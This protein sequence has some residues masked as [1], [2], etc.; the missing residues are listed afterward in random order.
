MKQIQIT[1]PFTFVKEDAAV[2]EISENEVL[3]KVTHIGICGSD[4]QIYH[5]KHKFMTFPVILGHEVAAL[6]ERAGAQ[7]KGFALGDQV[8]VE[9]QMACGHCY[10]CEHGR[11]N[12]CEHLKVLGVHAD[13]FSREY[14][15]LDTKYLHRVPKTMAGELAAMVEPFAVGVGSVRRSRNIQGA[16]VAVVGAGTIG[17]FT[18]QAAKLLG[19]GKVMISD[20]NQQK[21]DYALECGID[22]A[23]NTKNMSLKDAI[24]RCFGV[25]KADVII[26]CAGSPFTF[27]AILEAARPG[28][29]VIITANFKEPVEFNVPIMQRQEITLIGHMMY[30]REDFQTAIELL[31]AGKVVTSKTITKTFGFDEY[32]GAFKYADANA[33]SVMK[34]IVKL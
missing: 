1:A 20:I 14:V 23:V 12:V 32:E 29:E 21:L 28:S 13:G 31:A 3:L 19:A 11:F 26:D 34:L 30:V 18:A 5:G 10:P 4:M 22:E 2:P 17:N 16:N 25:R 24:G 15:A 33:D 9:P 27:K 6:I 7:V 8:T